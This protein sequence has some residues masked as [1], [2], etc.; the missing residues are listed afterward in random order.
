MIDLVNLYGIYWDLQN[1][2]RKF[3]HQKLSENT[4]G[5]I[6]EKA[7]DARRNLTDTLS[8]HDDELAEIIIK[9]ETLDNISPSSL[10]IAIRKT[11][12]GLKTFPVLCGSSYKN[13]GVQTL[14]DAIVNYLPS[15]LERNFYYKCF[16]NDMCGRAFK[17]QHDDQKGVLTFVRMFSGKIT[18][19]QKIYNIAKDKNEQV[20]SS[21]LTN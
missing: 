5:V 10:E 13:I 17:V 20:N 18:K 15:P 16:G 12:L 7:M 3:I 8:E 1:S 2:G 9:S 21:M 19:G 6:W 14:M 11:T 4:H